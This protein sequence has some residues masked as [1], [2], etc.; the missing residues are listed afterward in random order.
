MTP[1][2]IN[3]LLMLAI[4]ILCVVLLFALWFAGEWF[5]A[6][7]TANADYARRRKEFEAQKEKVSA[8]IKRA[9]DLAS[10]HASQNDPFK[11]TE[12]NIAAFDGRWGP[13]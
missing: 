12:D 13:D 10:E 4:G 1:L 9:G 8:S 2:L 7:R 6:W 3:I 11:R 5:R